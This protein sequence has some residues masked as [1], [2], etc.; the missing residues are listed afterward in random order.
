METINEKND[1]LGSL[2]EIKSP[3]K[4]SHYPRRFSDII[5][6]LKQT[7]LVRLHD[8]GKLGIQSDCLPSEGKKARRKVIRRKRPKKEDGLV[9]NSQ[10]SIKSYFSGKENV[11]NDSNGKRK[12]EDSP[13]EKSKKLKVGISD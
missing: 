6:K 4:L 9:E 13:T 3:N 12:N 8:L 5:P 2:L 11:G 7:S 1:G 10:M